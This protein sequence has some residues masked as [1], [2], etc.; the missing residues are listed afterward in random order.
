MRPSSGAVIVKRLIASNLSTCVATIAVALA[1]ALGATQSVAATTTPKTI[2]LVSAVGD[3]FSFVRQRQTTGTHFEG[4][5]RQTLK[6]PDQVLNLAVLRGLDRAMG[7]EYPESTRVFVTLNPEANAPEVLPQDREAYVFK[8]VL[9]LIEKMPE[10]QAWD[11]IVL[12]TPRWMF[13]ERAGM[14]SKLSGIGL[15]VQPLDGPAP[16]SDFDAG[17]P[18]EVETPDKEV[19]RSKTYVAP[20][21][22]TTVTTIDARTL[23]VIKQESRHDFRKIFDPKA[24]AID[25][26]NA[27]PPAQMAAMIERFVETAA[28]RSMTSKP[29]GSVEIGPLKST[30]A[31]EENAPKR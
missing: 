2:A 13:S 15:Y 23:K 7:A 5:T 25:V 4:F 21:F 19:V 1:C 18:D 29:V 3:Q 31:P 11:Q 30:P 8:R 14:G 27:I 16:G 10:R 28:L 24:T 20:F 26:Q 9:E 17:L 12:V 6:V 22:Y